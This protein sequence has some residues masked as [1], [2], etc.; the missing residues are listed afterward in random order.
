MEDGG[1]LVMTLTEDLEAED[2]ATTDDVL[3]A[4]LDLTELETVT[5]LETDTELDELVTEVVELADTELLE[6]EA[7]RAYNCNLTPAPQ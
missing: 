3:V 7:L 6:V 4:E 2:V 5:R 1:R